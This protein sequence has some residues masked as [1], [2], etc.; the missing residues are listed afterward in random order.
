[1]TNKNFQY[2]I[3]LKTKDLSDHTQP[4]VPG[5]GIFN[6]LNIFK[7]PFAS[8]RRKVS[9]YL[10]SP[11]FLK[12]E[13][14]STSSLSELSSSSEKNISNILFNIQKEYLNNSDLILDV[15]LSGVKKKDIVNLSLF[16]T[17]NTNTST[18]N[19]KKRILVQEFDNLNFKK[20]LDLQDYGKE[21]NLLKSKTFKKNYEEED[22]DDYVNDLVFIPFFFSDPY[23]GFFPL[24]RLCEGSYLE[25]AVSIKKQDHHDTSSPNTTIGLVVDTVHL[26]PDENFSIENARLINE[27]LSHKVSSSF[28]I[29]IISPSKE[30]DNKIL[31]DSTNENS[32]KTFFFDDVHNLE[33]IYGFAW[34]FS[35]QK[36]IEKLWN[37]YYTATFVEE[38]SS[39]SSQNTPLIFE[40]I[41]DGFFR[42]KKTGE[43]RIFKTSSRRK[44]TES[45]IKPEPILKIRKFPKRI[46]GGGGDDKK[47][48]LRLDV[49]FT[50]RKCL[51]EKS[52]DD[53]N[54]DDKSGNDPLFCF[55]DLKFLG[56]RLALFDE[57]KNQELKF[58]G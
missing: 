17:T 44:V 19:S 8:E 28:Y 10:K 1:M 54:D 43:W 37:M 50:R 55:I 31:L 9:W 24:S 26:T 46:G 34:R 57:N 11:F 22:D 58:I 3:D 32:S 30:T 14:T 12:P 48:S 23:N 25:V 18:N 41:P 47:S 56:F 2:L 39:S 5:L 49:V 16:Y 45:V 20:I 15:Y 13:T 7:T 27:P 6:P 21:Y 38:V 29:P 36:K 42:G 33:L 4:G 35:E 51:Q 52:K 40:N 53:D